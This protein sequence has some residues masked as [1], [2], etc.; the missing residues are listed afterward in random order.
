MSV[1]LLV[2]A[3]LT[4]APVQSGSAQLDNGRGAHTVTALGSPTGIDIPLCC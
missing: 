4:L 1:F 3:V 2:A